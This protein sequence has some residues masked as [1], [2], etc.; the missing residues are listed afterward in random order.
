MCETRIQN[1]S[2][3]DHRQKEQGFQVICVWKNRLG[4][5][6]KVRLLTNALKTI[7][8]NDV[9]DILVKHCLEKHTL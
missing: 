1:I 2:A 6:A 9:V 4:K 8:A 5:E 7:S 3:D